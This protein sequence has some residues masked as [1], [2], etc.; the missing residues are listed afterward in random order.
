MIP[1]VDSPQPTP[2]LVTQRAAERLP[3]VALLLFCAAYLLPGLFG[4]DPWRGADVT[5]F[6][7]MLGMAEGRTPWWA[8]TLGDLPPETAL[9]PHVFG[10]LAIKLLGPAMEPA[11]AARLAFAALLALTL[12][13]VWYATFHLARTE[14][15]QPI[16]FAFGGEADPVDYA[17]ARADGALL[18]IIAT[19]GLLQLGHETTPELMQLS[20]VTLLLWG[21]AA[22][23]YRSVAVRAALLLALPALAASGAPSMA[24]TLGLLALAVSLRSSYGEVRALWPWLL[25]SLVLAV[26]AAAALG[27]WQSRLAVPSAA[28]ILRLLLWFPWPVWPLALWTLWCWRRHWLRRHIAV[29]LATVVVGVVSAIA[30]GGSE[31]ALMLALPGMSVMAAFALPTLKRSAGAAVDWFSVFFFSLAAL[32]VWV[33]YLSM[34]TGVPAKPMAN[35]MRLAPGFVPRFSV[36]ELLAAALGTLAWL[37]LVRWRTSRH[38]HPLWKSLVLSASGVALA[39]LLTMTLL[40]PVLDYARSPRALV[41]L[42]DKYVP[43]GSCVLAPGMTRANVAALEVFGSHRVVTQPGQ[44]VPPDC[45]QH[46]VVAWRGSPL[47][48]APTGWTLQAHL[49]RPGERSDQMLVYRPAP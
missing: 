23:P 34:Q 11:L 44:S 9:L 24:V 4:R 35:I 6:G 25:S 36:V 41:S 42:V 3:R 17:R 21:L 29:P 1:A 13:L 19:L 49:R 12:A 45:D 30:M 31:R 27:A 8:P 37:W 40:L 2:A 38:R 33:I 16:P 7:T 28:G 10:A 39:W 20:E 18:A 48:P 5:A 15:A 46:L 14:A 22:A 32:T 47:P 26:A 43:H